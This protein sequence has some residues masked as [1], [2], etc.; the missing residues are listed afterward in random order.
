[1][2]SPTTCYKKL[3]KAQFF[4]HADFL[5]PVYESLLSLGGVPTEKPVLIP[6]QPWI[7]VDSEFIDEMEN[8]T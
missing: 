4:D 3:K 1:M 5:L 6:F 7:S 8:D 2:D